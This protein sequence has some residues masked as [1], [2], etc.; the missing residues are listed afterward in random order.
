[1]GWK[2]ARAAL[3]RIEYSV[4]VVVGTAHGGHLDSNL[5]G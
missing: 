4:F 3:G 5:D 1:M 2:P